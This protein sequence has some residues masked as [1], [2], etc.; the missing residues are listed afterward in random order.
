MLLF[1]HEG[2]F[3]QLWSNENVSKAAFF[4]PQ[5]KFFMYNFGNINSCLLFCVI[6]KFVHTVWAIHL[7][8]CSP[9]L[10]FTQNLAWISIW[11]VYPCSIAS[12]PGATLGCWCAASSNKKSSYDLT[13][14]CVCIYLSVFFTNYNIKHEWPTSWANHFS[15]QTFVVQL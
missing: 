3:F 15:T 8:W 2:K 5:T 11:V 14:F 10:G 7:T 4:F 9:Q 12:T 13:I 6:R 1:H